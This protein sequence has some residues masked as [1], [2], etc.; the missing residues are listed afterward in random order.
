MRLPRVA[1]VSYLAG[2][3]GIFSTNAEGKK[4]VRPVVA[5]TW[6]FGH[7]AVKEARVLLEAGRDSVTAVEQGIR[8]VELDNAEQYFVGVGGFPNADGHMELDA[9][10]MDHNMNY[11]AVM[12]LQSIKNPISVARSVME[13]SVHNVLVGEGA[14]KW[15]LS[16]GFEISAEVLTKAMKDEWHKWKI[17]NIIEQCKNSNSNINVENKVFDSDD[18]HDTIGIIC[19]DSD[20]KLCAGTSTSGWKF[21][22]PGRVGDSPI[23]GSG[24]Y[25]DGNVGAAVA[26]GDGEEI[27][28]L[29]LSAIVVEYMRHGCTPQE[30]CAKGIR[31]MLELEISTLER[32]RKQFEERN[33]GASNIEI[34]ELR[35]NRNSMHAQLTVGVI[36]MNAAGEVGAASTI[37]ES[38]LHRGLATFPVACWRGSMQLDISSNISCRDDTF[39]SSTGEPTTLYASVDGSSF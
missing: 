7:L 39:Q 8:L 1:I 29:C 6:K 37:R 32:L 13:K 35:T 17:E 22:H 19:L 4:K 33:V 5:A 27:M 38:N 21:K 12:G 18:Q 25:C 31:R 23:V 28:R 30:A 15:A 2:S 14:L 24:L 3:C 36:A 10:I 9:A 34:E 11:G 26:T 16:Q 20:G